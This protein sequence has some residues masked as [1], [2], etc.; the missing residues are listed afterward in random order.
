MACDLTT[1]QTAACVSGIGREQS[2][3]KLLQLIAQLTCEAS[4]GAGS[5]VWGSIT[6]TLS[7]Q[8]DLDTALDLR[9]LASDN[10]ADVAD[11]QTSRSNLGMQYFAMGATAAVAGTAG[12]ETLFTFQLPANSLG[13]NGCLFFHIVSTFTSSA[14]SKALRVQIG[15]STVQ[16]CNYFNTGQSG[17]MHFAWKNRGATN[18]QIAGLNG[19]V[20]AFSGASSTALFTSA[21]DTTVA[22]TVNV[23][24][25]KANAGETVTL[26][27][28]VA[29][30]VFIQ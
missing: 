13:T 5:A 20:G 25:L 8:T 18:S 1:I 17:L 27:G 6:G 15:G 22:Q 3:I 19:S 16:E 7:N 28:V 30:A 24:M 23:Q 2:Q 11:S 26:Q 21:I 29:Q 12:Y 10:L 14:N 9:L 4:E